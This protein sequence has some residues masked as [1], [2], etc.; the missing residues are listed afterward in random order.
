GD[1]LGKVKAS[2]PDGDPLTYSISGNAGP[3]IIGESN[4][5][6]GLAEGQSLDYD[7]TN[8]YT[9]TIGVTDNTDS[10][11]ETITINVTNVNQAP[12][13]A[14]DQVFSVYEDISDTV[15]IGQVSA[16][17][18]DGDGITFSVATQN[19]IFEIS[20][21]GELTLVT[22]VSLDYETQTEY[23]V[24]I[25]VGDGTDTVQETIT[26]VVENVIDAPYD[27]EKSSFV[28]T[29]ETTEAN[30]SVTLGIAEGG[31]YNYILDWGDGTIEEV[32]CYNTPPEHTYTVADIYTISVNTDGIDNGAFSRILW[33]NNP[34]ATKVK[35]IEQWGTIK[36]GSF[37]NA[38]EGCTNMV[39]NATDAPD[40]ENVTS[41]WAMFYGCSSFNGDLSNWDVST[42]TSMGNMFSGA[43]SFNGNI[44][45][46][47]VENVTN[48]VFMF[49]GASTFNQDISGWDVSKVENMAVMFNGA[50]SFNQN[51]G[52]WKIIA[53]AQGAT[54]FALLNNSALTNEN[55]EATLIGWSNLQGVPIG[56]DL[57]AQGLE[58]C[59]AEALEA[60]NFLVNTKEWTID[61][62]GC[63]M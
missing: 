61:D 11:T 51:L 58:R 33:D 20:N 47:V 9:L 55:Y 54:M 17:D 53:L 28:F 31:N 34:D 38:F 30:E 23:T 59:S 22:G 35:S 52:D 18:P 43:S 57:G 40:L 45:N 25:E 60:V 6:L 36:W 63:N 21:A 26:I 37:S 27:L 56:I 4:G 41:L 3:F 13:I 8:T 24:T 49:D 29:M 39:Y 16:S 7:T 46:W 2:D 5:E 12:T 14:E 15:L 62:D 44:G 42:I 50:S 19:D 10:T 48:M 1:N 32:S